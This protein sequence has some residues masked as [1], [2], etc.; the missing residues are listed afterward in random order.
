MYSAWI[1]SGSGELLI[2]SKLAN[3]IT[4]LALFVEETVI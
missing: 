4:G 1:V 3:I 2:K